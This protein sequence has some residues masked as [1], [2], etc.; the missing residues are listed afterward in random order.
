MKAVAGKSEAERRR[1]I[2]RAIWL[3]GEIGKLER[4]GKEVLA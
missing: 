3:M 1:E 2:E 4:R